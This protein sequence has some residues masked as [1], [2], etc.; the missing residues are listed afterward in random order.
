MSTRP[1]DLPLLVTIVAKNAAT[2]HGLQ[3][4]LE[5]AGVHVTTTSAMDRVLETTPPAAAAVI[6]FPD[7]YPHDAAVGA[8]ALLRKDR[9]QT[10]RVIVTQEPRRFDEADADPSKLAAPLILP[11]PAWAW[12]ILDAV[13][14]RL[15]T[16][17]APGAGESETHA[18]RR[19]RP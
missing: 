16:L 3:T 13:R 4:Y 8:L 17:S 18:A 5:G 6:V 10:M 19:S 1:K 11:K 15:V 12:T 14:A 9:A 7:E 2:L